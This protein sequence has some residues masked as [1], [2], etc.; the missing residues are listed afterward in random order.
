MRANNTIS[1]GL[2]LL[3][4]CWEMLAT[5]F[6]AGLRLHFFL[7]SSPSDYY[8]TRW[9]MPSFVFLG[10]ACDYPTLLDMPAFLFL[11]YT[12]AQ[13]YKRCAKPAFF[14]WSM[15]TTTTIHAGL[16]FL[17]CCWVMLANNTLKSALLMRLCCRALPA[18]TNQH[19]GI[20]MSLGFCSLPANSTVHAAL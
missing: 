16:C 9:A 20:C 6:H 18:G 11:G 1:D 7:L 17:F 3:L 10:S 13:Y 4:Y 12:C 8:S 2:Y 15:R 19:A 5:S 14:C